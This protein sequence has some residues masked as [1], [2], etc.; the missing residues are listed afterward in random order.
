MIIFLYK[1]LTSN[2]EIGNKSEIPPSELNIWRLGGVRNTKFGV[3]V[4]N[5]IL[6]N[7]AKGQ[8][9]RFY[10]FWVIK[11]KLTGEE[12]GITSLSSYQSPLHTHTHTQIEVNGKG[13]FQPFNVTSLLT[14]PIRS[15][16]YL[17]DEELAVVTSAWTFI[18]FFETAINFKMYYHCTH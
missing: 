10:R 6:F 8:C 17:A 3:N 9:Y 7:A 14:S 5:K 1:G 2:S 15:D 16:L 13:I 18:S 12:G 11:E 4:S